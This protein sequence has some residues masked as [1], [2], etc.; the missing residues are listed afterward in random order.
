M[1]PTQLAQRILKARKPL[2]FVGHGLRLSGS[3]ALFWQTIHEFEIP[4]MITSHAKGLLDESSP[5]FLGTMGFACDP[6]IEDR[7]REY[8]ADLIVTLGT[9][10]GELASLGWN[11]V[12][13]ESPLIQVLN[14][15]TDFNEAYPH[16]EKVTADLTAVLQELW[17]QSGRPLQFQKIIKKNPDRADASFT[18]KASPVDPRE[19]IQALEYKLPENALLVSDIGNSMAWV[20][21]EMKING[22]REFYLPLGLGS[23]GSGIGAAIGAKLAQP[24]RP[25]FCI[26]GDCSMLMHGSEVLT[27]KENKAGVIFLILND[28]GHGMV[29]HG[30]RLLGLPNVQVRFRDPVDFKS[31]GQAFQLDSHTV[32]SVDELLHLPWGNWE[33]STNP[34]VVDIRIDAMIEPPIKSRIRVLGQ[35]N[36]VR[37]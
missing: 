12:L 5:L 13:S 19:L 33:Q 35:A 7:I 25:V 21:R 28:S 15:S 3:S 10:L 31:W 32:N 24:N 36:Q 23:M 17:H 20:I 16:A 8:Q 26:T 11:Q 4:F 9:R 34:V 2:F 22:Q 27:A 37:T 18:S 1:L 29:D 14:E 6:K 30:H